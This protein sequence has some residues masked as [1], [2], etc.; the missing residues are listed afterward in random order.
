LLSSFAFTLNSTTRATQRKISRKESPNTHQDFAA[1]VFI[2]LSSASQCFSLF[3]A[4]VY[5]QYS[6]RRCFVLLWKIWNFLLFAKEKLSSIRLWKFTSHSS[7]LSLL[8]KL[9]HSQ[10]VI[11]TRR[12]CGNRRFSQLSTTQHEAFSITYCHARILL[13]F[14]QRRYSSYLQSAN[15]TYNSSFF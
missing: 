14:A 10:H 15:L 5:S 2:A 6:P 4:T 12:W 8:L 13:N 1:A 9:T 7:L 3:L 11:R